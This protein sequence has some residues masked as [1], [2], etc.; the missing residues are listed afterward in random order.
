MQDEI[1][2]LPANND[3]HSYAGIDVGKRTLDVFISP[4]GELRQFDNDAKGLRELVL[5]CRRNRV[6]LVALEATGRYHRKAHEA[7]HEA[8]FAV[9]VI[10]PF[11]SRKFAGAVGRLA[12]TDTIDAQVLARFAMLLRPQPTS[13]QSVQHKALRDLNVARRQ[14]LDEVGT[15]KR[16]L[17]ET[18]HPLAQR[19]IRARIKMAER[20]QKLL[21]TE[22]QALIQGQD[23][24]RHRFDILTSIPGI[25]LVT[26]TTLLTELEELG[27]VNCRQIAALAGLAPMN[28]DSG[29]RKGARSIR[30]GRAYVR[31]MLFMC[32]VGL[33]RRNG[34]MGTFYRRLVSEGKNPKVAMTA[35]ARKLVI[36][37]NTLIAEDR[38]WQANAPQRA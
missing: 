20:H 6:R 9:A 10:N 25:G 38:R 11:R 7:L 4:A 3:E 28:N 12:K 33:S 29:A 2:P 17:Y 27:Q 23:D 8:G 13:P 18:E 37:A 1:T 19:Q 21:E 32:A 36:L 30:G 26:A 15:L 31:R 35:M 22:I 16:Q 34:I 5:H 24:L 14:V